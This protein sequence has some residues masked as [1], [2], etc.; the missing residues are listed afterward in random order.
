[1]NIKLQENLFYKYPKI[2]RQKELTIKESCMYWGIEC[3]DGWYNLLDH[4]CWK[5]QDICDNGE[6]TYI[7]YPKFIR[8]IA[9]KLGISKLYGYWKIKKVHQVEFIQVKEKFG[10]LRIYKMGGNNITD[11]LIEFVEVL[12]GSVCEYCGTMKNVSQTKGWIKTIC[13][14]CLKKE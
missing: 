7:Y 4:I 8:F 5:I 14:D 3:D 10:T 11:E 9:K 12:S 13:E 2:F 1:M 6:K